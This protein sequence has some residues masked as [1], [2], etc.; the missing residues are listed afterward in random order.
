MKK[1]VAMFKKGSIVDFQGVEHPF[2]VCALSTNN[3]QTEEAKIA[4]TTFDASEYEI[5]SLFVPR[6]VFI[7]VSVCN[8]C[9]EWDEEKGKMI[10]L[11]KAKGFKP[12]LI[13]KSAALFA[14]RPG[15]ISTELVEALLTREVAHIQDNPESVIPGYNQMK[16][17]FEEQQ[18]NEKFLK[19]T[20][21]KLMNIVDQLNSLTSEELEHTIKA[22]LLKGNE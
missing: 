6:A 21:E 10:A 12:E 4:I 3:F 1:D 5:D 18:E 22:A 9:D 19:K 7:G 13:E 2:I 14:T 8:P 17:R 16:A 11:S 20:P 15:L